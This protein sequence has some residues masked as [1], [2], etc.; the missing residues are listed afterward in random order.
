LVAGDHGLIAADLGPTQLRA[1][2]RRCWSG[3]SEDGSNA[4]RYIAFST[5]PVEYRRDFSSVRHIVK[6]AGNAAA[7]APF[8]SSDAVVS[9]GEDCARIA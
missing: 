9:D 8:L 5:L 6:M 2:F 7:R 4:S 1:T 3:S